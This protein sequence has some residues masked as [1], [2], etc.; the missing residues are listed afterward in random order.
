[1]TTGTDAEWRDRGKAENVV[2]VQVFGRWLTVYFN[3]EYEEE[4][5]SACC[6]KCKGPA[7]VADLNIVAIRHSGS[8]RPISLASHIAQE[9]ARQARLQK[10]VLCLNCLTQG[11]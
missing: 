3:Y 8:D 2:E 11:R 1:M 7:D 10:E 5:P 4:P 6:V 9:A